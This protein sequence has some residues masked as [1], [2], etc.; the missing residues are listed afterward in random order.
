MKNLSALYDRNLSEEIVIV[1]VDLNINN[2]TLRV[3]GPNLR[4]TSIIPTIKFL[5][6]RGAKV[7]LVS[8]R[9][10]PAGVTNNQRPITD[11]IKEFTL[12]PFAKILGGLLKKDVSFIPHDTKEYRLFSDAS[13][14]K[15]KKASKGSVFLLENMRFF[16]GEEKND[17]AV[18]RPLA[19]LGTFYVNDAFA[20]S[21][22]KNASVVAIT[23][24]LPSCA[25]LLLEKE[26]FHMD[27]AINNH[28]HPFVVILGGAKMTDKMGLIKRFIG[29]ADYFLAGGGVANTFFAADGLPIGD[30]IYESHMIPVAKKIMKTNKVIMPM[31][32]AIFE[33]KIVDNGPGT[34]D[35][36]VEIIKNAKTII[37]NGPVGVIENK[38]FA[39][40]SV[41]IAQAIAKSKAFSVV[42]GG[43]TALAFTGVP[44]KKNT[45]LST[46]GG[47]MLEYLSGIKLP[48]IEALREKKGKGKKK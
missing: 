7:V 11:N 30:S 2:K 29:K 18:V 40:G 36:W 44:L 1:R 45:F 22:R 37:W 47:A 9:G 41:G 13:A 6:K 4:V 8:H 5:T 15:I 39:K 23:K 48:G 19:E 24:L 46:G 27:E 42:G 32:V 20:V 16:A 12:K 3:S 31:D 10:R 28:K 38:K 43:E 33:R 17:P 34:T 14:E 21:H 35:E 25:G 26:V